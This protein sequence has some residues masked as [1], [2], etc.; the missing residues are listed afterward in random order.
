MDSYS[1][2]TGITPHQH[3]AVALGVLACSTGQGHEMNSRTGG[4]SASRAILDAENDD[5]WFVIYDIALRSVV[6]DGSIDNVVDAIARE[7]PELLTDKEQRDQVREEIHLKVPDGMIQSLAI[8][9]A[10]T[11]LGAWASSMGRKLGAARSTW[12]PEASVWV[13]V[14]EAAR[15]GA[16][17]EGRAKAKDL[18]DGRI[19][20]DEFFQSMKTMASQK[21]EEAIAP[22]SITVNTVIETAEETGVGAHN[23]GGLSRLWGLFRR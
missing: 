8:E 5:I 17:L 13:D 4:T 3:A 18:Q 11:S 1:D 19:I 16:M 22:L 9:F 21:A 10:A 7:L 6:I 2:E 14:F 23:K 12:M 20:A 15:D